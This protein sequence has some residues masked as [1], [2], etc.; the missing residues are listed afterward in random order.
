MFEWGQPGGGADYFFGAVGGVEDLPWAAAAA[1]AAAASAGVPLAAATAAAA[2]D[3]GSVGGAPG[4]AVGVGVAVALPAGAAAGWACGL[5]AV[6]GLTGLGVF[7]FGFAVPVAWGWP[8][9]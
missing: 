2:A 4:A 8:A 7:F 6:C 1:A 9:G 3:A 5:R